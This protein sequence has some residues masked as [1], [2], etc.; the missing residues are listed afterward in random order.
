MTG[1]L[2]ANVILRH[3]LGDVPEQSSAAT[4][5]IYRIARDEFQAELADA[6]VFEVVFTLERTYKLSRGRARELI[7]PLLGLPGM[8][9]NPELLAALDMHVERK[10]SLPD[11]YLIVRAL[12]GSG[13]VISFDRD[14]DRIP[15]L[16]RIEPGAV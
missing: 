4:E 15:G 2:D 16:Q 7:L 5:L 9:A 13:Q 12:Q 3:L 1:L 6:I 8:S 14:F 10:L 11:A